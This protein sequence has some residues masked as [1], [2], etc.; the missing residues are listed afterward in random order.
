M[1]KPTKWLCAQQRFRS[2][3]A[4]AQS[5]QI[6]CPVWSESSLSAWRNLGPLTTHWAHSED[7]DQTGRMPRLIWVFAGHTAT[8]LVLSWGGSYYDVKMKLSFALEAAFSKFSQTMCLS[9]PLLEQEKRAFRSLFS[10]VLE[11]RNIFYAII[12]IK[13][14]FLIH[15]HLLGPSGGVEILAFQAR[16]RAVWSESLLSV[17]SRESLATMAHRVPSNGWSDC[18]AARHAWFCRFCCARAHVT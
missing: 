18:V 4:F 16:V 15:L 10:K 8:L 17:W 7:T 2:A 5:D 9:G 3:L 12:A 13:Y 6:K 14:D 1:T 11:W